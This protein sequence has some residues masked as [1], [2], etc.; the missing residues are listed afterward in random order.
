M[1][2]VI[3]L[4]TAKTIGEALAGARALAADEQTALTPAAVQALMSHITGRG[5]AWLLAHPEDC[6]KPEQIRDFSAAVKRLAEGEPLAYLTGMRAF[7]WLDFFVTPDVLIP[8]PET[9]DL[10]EEVITWVAEHKKDS[11]SR[12]IDIGAGSGAIG[13]A[14]AYRLRAARVIATDVSLN[15]LSVARRN[16]QAHQVDDRMT[17]VCSDLLGGISGP[18]DVIAANLP[19]IASDVLPTLDV[20][21]WEPSL[22]LDGGMDGLKLIRELISQAPHYLAPDGLLILEI[23]YDQGCAVEKLCRAAFPSARV[24]VSTDLAGLD[25]RVSVALA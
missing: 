20:S 19:Y 4:S 13:I 7:F 6:L 21:R 8:R 9:E 22:A 24:S 12:I 11:P 2:P 1:Q 25:R 17:F 14:L 3:D 16:A 18:F 5:R 15:A 23:G 10:V